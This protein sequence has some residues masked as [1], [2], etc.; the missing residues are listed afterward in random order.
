M[1]C[2]I[3]TDLDLVASCD[4][5]PLTVALQSRCVSPL[6]VTAGEDGRWYT[7]L[8]TDEQYD[9]PETTIC[10]MLDAIDSLNKSNRS[11]WIS[12]LVREFNI[13]FDCGDKPWAFNEGLTNATLR[14]IGKVGAT[15]RITLYPPEKK[16]PARRK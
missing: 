15:L 3:N 13:G 12:C 4:L 8:E 1:I 6:H 16:M 5:G 2:Y 9:Q 14:R 11:Y 10:A 7:T